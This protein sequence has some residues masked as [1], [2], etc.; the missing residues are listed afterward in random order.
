MRFKKIST[1]ML[2]TIL[3]VIM[4]AMIV[5]TLVSM[6]SSRSI[7]D[8]QNLASMES[9]LMA[10]NGEMGSYLN[11]VSDMATT[12]AN[13]VETSYRSTEMAE[14]EKMLANII[15]ANDIVLGSGLWFEPY[16]YD[17]EEEYM[18]PY[19][20]KDGDSTLTTYDYSNALILWALLILSQMMYRIFLICQISRM[21]LYRILMR[22]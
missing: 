17:S 16:A 15:S 11:S 3:P 14:Y 5:L 12:I 6:N 21:S 4:L 18:G 20:Y 22:W 7:I 1:K 2:A 13:M 19:V 8:K 9:E 10:Q